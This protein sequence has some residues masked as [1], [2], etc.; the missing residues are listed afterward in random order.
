MQHHRAYVQ[1]G[2][3]WTVAADGKGKCPNHG[4]NK[5]C[6]KELRNMRLGKMSREKF[7]LE[8]LLLHGR[9]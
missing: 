3:Q 5:H 7:V 2:L 4:V 9:C 6:N 1:H 8:A